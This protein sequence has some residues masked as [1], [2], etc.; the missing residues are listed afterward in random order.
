[1]LRPRH[2][3]VMQHPNAPDA[4]LFYVPGPV[5]TEPAMAAI[6]HTTLALPFLRMLG[7][8]YP[9]SGSIRPLQGPTLMAQKAVTTASIGIQEGQFAIPALT[10][11]DGSYGG[12]Y[13]PTD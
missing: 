11:T 3:T 5:F 13:E 9:I 10:D 2:T 7:A 1:M 8:G 6:Y 4:P 12:G